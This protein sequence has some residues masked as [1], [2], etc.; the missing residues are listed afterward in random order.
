LS[1]FDKRALGEYWL[2]H[3][4]AIKERALKERDRQV[5]TSSYVASYEGDLPSVYK[6]LDKLSGKAN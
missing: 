5:L 3:R 6:V 4:D 1:G 2:K